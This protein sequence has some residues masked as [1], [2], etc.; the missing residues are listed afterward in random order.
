MQTIIFPHPEWDKLFVFKILKVNNESKTHIFK[1]SHNLKPSYMVTR[2]E[3]RGGT[4]AGHRLCSPHE[5]ARVHSRPG[6]AA[7]A[8]NPTGW[9]A[10][11]KPGG[12]PGV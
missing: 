12:S 8:G 6:S 7:D 9:R 11:L 5:D 1:I 3:G 4:C 10:I 2:T